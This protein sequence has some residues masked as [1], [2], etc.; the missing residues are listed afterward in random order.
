MKM[1]RPAHL[2]Q[3]IGRLLNRA[4]GLQKGSVTMTMKVDV[5]AAC[6]HCYQKFHASL[7]RVVWAETPGMRDMIFADKINWLKCPGCGTESHPAYAMMYV[8]VKRNF[9]VWY[10]PVHDEEIDQE[11]S[12]YEKMCG[13]GNFY[14]TAPRVSDWAMF[15]ETILQFERGELRGKPLTRESV[16]L[17]MIS[18]LQ[19]RVSQPKAGCLFVLVGLFA[20]M[21]TKFGGHL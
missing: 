7:Y 3:V 6:G 19:R 20:P 5:N 15:K 10:E 4:D 16:S 1:A 8:D 12:G 17:P 11:L 21:L 18:Q 14:V 2:R 13:A 9:A